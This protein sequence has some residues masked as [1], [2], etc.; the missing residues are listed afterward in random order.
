MRRILS[1]VLNLIAL[2]V[3][4]M[5]SLAQAAEK[6]SVRTG[7]HDGYSRVVFAWPAT[8]SYTAQTSGNALTLT[9]TKEAE[10]TIDGAAPQAITRITGFST[11]PTSATITHATGQT[12]RH[13]VIGNRIIVDIKG[14]ASASDPAAAVSPQTNAV[15]E[16]ESSKPVELLTQAVRDTPPIEAEPPKAEE[17]AAATAVVAPAAP[18]APEASPKIVVDKTAPPVAEAVKPPPPKFDA[19]MINIT[20]TQAIG[21]AVFERSGVLWLVIDQENYPIFP[22]LAGP[23]KDSF[24]QFE[25]ISLKGGTAFTLKLPGTFKIYGEGGGL[26]WKVVLTPNPRPSRAV[27]FTRAFDQTKKPGGRLVW[28]VADARNIIDITDPQVG[29]DLKAVTVI[30]SKSFSGSPQDYVEFSTLSAPIGLVLRPKVDDLVVAKGTKDVTLSREPNGLALSAESDLATLKLQSQKKA[31]A[32]PDPDTPAVS[33]AAASNA[34]PVDNR[35][36]RIFAF[37]NWLMGGPSALHENQ[38]IIMSAISEKTDQGKAEDLITLAKM[39][40]AN[41]RGPE[42]L[43]FLDFANQLVKDLS[44]NPEFIALRGAAESLHGQC[45]QGFRD[46]S[47]KSLDAISEVKYW[48]AYCLA[49]LEDWKQAEEIMPK[50]ISLLA[51]YPEGVQIPVGLTLTE[52]ALRAGDTDTADKILEILEANDDKLSLAYRSA[53]DYLRGESR[54]Q[55]GDFGGMKDLWTPLSTGPDDLYRAKAGLAL[56]SQLLEKKEITPEAAIDKLEGLRYAWR[57]DELETA[58]NYKLGRVYIEGNQPIKGLTLLRQ[59]AS[60]APN[61]DLGQQI[62][63]YMTN[64]FKSLYLDN[65]IKDLNP[66]D[67]VTIYDEFAELI[68]AGPEG[69]KVSRQLAERLVDADLLPRAENILQAQVNG[70]VTGIEGAEV[71]LRLASIQL[72]DGKPDKALATL[73]KA[74]EML[75]TAPVEQGTS[76]RREIALLRARALS[77]Q[78]KPEEAFAALSLLQQEPDVLRLRADIAWRAKRWQDAADTLEELV[79]KLNIDMTKPM[80]ADEADT[81][82]NW[83]VALYLADNRFVLANLR[84]KYADAMAQTPLSR[85]FDVI[86][87]PRQN[88][89]LA[90]RA[91]INSIIG[92]TDIFKGF[93]DSFTAPAQTS[94]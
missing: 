5:P 58:I 46:F 28:P 51:H 81:V 74:D 13:F 43:G 25:Q 89:L 32:M 8:P 21:M 18:V 60:L 50:D 59:S 76:K 91:T 56:A 71:A 69:D 9:F 41:G 85:K 57:G 82:M 22:Q 6:V 94:Q 70:R 63:A 10:F 72:L 49:H 68:P 75:L 83:A 93:L 2:A 92:E 34:P 3:V 39:E 29:D 37:D 48:R 86:T 7:V 31:A 40:L 45:D 87:R 30:A 55:Q 17:P 33:E 66:I 77:E 53:L 19:H 44:T 80:N 54:R 36:T 84:E 16:P 11:T 14:P 12:V 65:K 90:D 38:R 1:F 27:E 42:A 62:T 78:K 88:S 67:A 20:G 73:T 52:V 15:A 23:Q 47:D 61:S 24:P 4:L 64:T 79:N 26:I 35:F